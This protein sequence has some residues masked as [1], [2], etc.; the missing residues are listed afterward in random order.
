M[1]K[2]ASRSSLI[3]ELN[4]FIASPPYRKDN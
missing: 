3:C 1:L 4:M 2:A